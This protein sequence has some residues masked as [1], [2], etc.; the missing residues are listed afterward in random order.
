MKTQERSCDG[1]LKLTRQE[2]REICNQ[3]RK[4]GE[5]QPAVRHRSITSYHCEFCG[6]WHVGHSGATV[7]AGYKRKKQFFYY[8]SEE[9]E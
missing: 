9:A 7:L 6:G 8:E 3:I 4:R 2:A 1:K 5:R